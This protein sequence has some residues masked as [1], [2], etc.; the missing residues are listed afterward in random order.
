VIANV[1]A[2]KPA[3]TL[4]RAHAS[5]VGVMGEVLANY[6]GV[7]WIGT[8]HT[9]DWVLVTALGPGKE[10]FAGIQPHKEAFHRMLRLSGISFRNPEMTPEQAKRYLARA[11]RIR[12]VHWT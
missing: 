6:F 3:P 9:G 1:A 10:M 8:Q 7:A 4:N 2:G 11:P 12:P 5:L